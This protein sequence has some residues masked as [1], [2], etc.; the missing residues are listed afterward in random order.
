MVAAFTHRWHLFVDESGDF[1]DLAT[2]VVVAAV[3]LRLDRV[4][5]RPD[6]LGNVL[7]RL[8]PGMPW[9]LHLCVVRRLSALAMAPVALRIRAVAAV[10]GAERTALKAALAALDQGRPPEP[11][12]LHRVACRLGGVAEA[13]LAWPVER[14]LAEHASHWRALLQA[15]DPLR[16]APADLWAEP[17]FFSVSEGFRDPV[18]ATRHLLCTAPKEAHRVAM[19]FACGER[20]A[21]E[22][23]SYLDGL[24]G[25]SGFGDPLKRIKRRVL[26]G[27]TRLL[28]TL[29][30]P[31]ASGLPG[32]LI[33]VAGESRDGDF[34]P[35][36]S[37]DD[38]YL[39]VLESLLTRTAETLARLPGSHEVEVRACTRLVADPLLVTRERRTLLKVGHLEPLCERV[40]GRV[41]RRVRLWP[42][43]TPRYHDTRDPGF[44]LADFVA[45]GSLSCLNERSLTRVEQDLR[46]AFGA[47]PRSGE[48]PRTHLQATGAAWRLLEALRSSADPVEEPMRLWARE[49]AVEW[50]R[51]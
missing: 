51:P 37:G 48:P 45:N 3:A 41:A 26:A 21:W 29:A 6:Q 2:R 24:L 49:Q 25:R 28:G 38:R 33:F 27:I 50:G 11:D 17:D 4:L 35:P 1:E 14:I 18:A 13:G 10:A 32:A 44:V 40:E 36:G 22:D 20:V 42:V 39:S 16:E 9:P 5:T 7:R 31:D 15:R 19:A 34:W 23:L 43:E 8:A 47:A 30:V 12:A 46:A